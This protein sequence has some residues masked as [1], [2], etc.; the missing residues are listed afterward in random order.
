MMKS[1]EED[2]DELRGDQIKTYFS[3]NVSGVRLNVML[4]CEH[5]NDWS[6]VS[7]FEHKSNTILKGLNALY[8]KNTYL[9]N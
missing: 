3:F 6:D 2:E 9:L 4:C 8:K 5:F 7:C 1:R